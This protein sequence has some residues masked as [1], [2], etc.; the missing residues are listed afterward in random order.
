MVYQTTPLLE[1]RSVEY[2]VH[3]LS[4]KELL[5]QCRLK[6]NFFFWVFAIFFSRLLTDASPDFTAGNP[7]FSKLICRQF[8][9]GY[10]QSLEDTSILVRVPK[11]GRPIVVIL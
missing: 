9:I 4:S 6:F 3:L 5:Q 2:F 1:V 11:K 7:P 8:V 10:S